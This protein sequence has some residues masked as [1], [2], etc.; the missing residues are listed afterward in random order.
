MTR[1][2]CLPPIIDKRARVLILGSFPSEASLAAKHYY[3]H[4]QNQFWRVMSALL[5]SDLTGM[6]YERKQA[7][8]KAGGIAVWDIY[9]SC[10]REGSLDSA[11]R[12]GAY[13]DFTQLRQWAPGL[14]K[15][16]F[17]GLAAARPRRLVE[18]LGYEVCQ[19]PST[20]PAHASRS[21]ADK[22]KSWRDGLGIR[23]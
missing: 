14:G 8:L 23:G 4:P 7:A 1:L 12:Q 5:G 11:I 19:L 3:A 20:S 22:V 10:E 9:A 21:L 18:G 13:N 2:Y 16:G 15:I 6:D 17:N